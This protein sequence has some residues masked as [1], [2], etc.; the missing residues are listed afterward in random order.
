MKKP[1]ADELLFGKLVKGG[2][3]MV[4]VVKDKLS[5][6]ILSRPSA[7]VREEGEGDDLAKEPEL[8]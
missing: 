5:F 8:A 4:T 3:V 7:E 1:L 2:T 6:T